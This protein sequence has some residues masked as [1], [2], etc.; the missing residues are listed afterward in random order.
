MKLLAVFSR[1]SSIKEMWPWRT[2]FSV[3]ALS[4]CSRSVAEYGRGGNAVPSRWFR[5][6]FSV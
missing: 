2:P 1:F 3:V 4:Q 6:P 5:D